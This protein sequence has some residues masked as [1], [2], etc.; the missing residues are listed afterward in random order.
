MLTSERTE[1]GIEPAPFLS[2]ATRAFFVKGGILVGETSING[3]LCDHLAFRQSNADWQLWVEKGARPLPRK[4]VITTRYEV[5]DP[6]FQ[7]TMTWNV[8]PRID[9]STFAFTP[10][11]GAEE[12]PFA[13]AAAVQ[14]GGNN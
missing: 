14:D 12:I 4:V 1:A 6:Q 13:D 3:V 10:P 8:Q 5:G 9:K 11:S 7:A 2:H